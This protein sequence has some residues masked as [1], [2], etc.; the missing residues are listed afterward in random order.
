MWSHKKSQ[1]DEQNCKNK[2]G[3]EIKMSWVEKNRKINNWGEGAI[4]RD[5]VF[6]R[7]N[8]KNIEEKYRNPSLIR[9][10]RGLNVP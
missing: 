10:C 7:K 3:V 4:I 2:D 6:F 1:D 8:K 9:K 5:M